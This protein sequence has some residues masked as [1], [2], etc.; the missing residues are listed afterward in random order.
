MAKP[1]YGSS[2]EELRCV[3]TPPEDQNIQVYLNQINTIL[4]QFFTQGS[5]TLTVEQLQT[6]STLL[7]L[8][9]SRA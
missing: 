3:Y 8:I 1:I 6:L 4:N 7:N 5:K 9:K 2:I